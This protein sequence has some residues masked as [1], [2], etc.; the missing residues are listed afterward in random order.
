MASFVFQEFHNKAAI[1]IHRL[2]I[3]GIT[4]KSTQKAKSGT[5]FSSPRY[6]NHQNQDSD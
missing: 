4:Q 2:E 6:A 3:L 1:E 5:F